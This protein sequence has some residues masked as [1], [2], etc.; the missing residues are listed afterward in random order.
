M[1]Y[2]VGESYPFVAIL[3][4]R[5]DHK[6]TQGMGGTFLPWEHKLI[7]IHVE[8]LKCIEHH[9]VPNY[10]DES[11]QPKLDCDGFIFQ[12]TG[13]AERWNNQYPRAEYGQMSDRADRIVTL[14]ADSKEFVE[15]YWD[16]KVF[17]MEDALSRLSEIHRGVYQLREQAEE[18]KSDPTKFN[19]ST[20]IIFSQATQLEEFAGT[21]QA[22][23]EEV[24]TKKIVVV[25]LTYRMKDS[26]EVHTLKGAFRARFENQSQNHEV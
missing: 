1:R 8:V 9:K 25:P 15:K 18:A 12:N 20:E 24:C 13:F 23:L 4:Q 22:K 26:P 14:A 19:V 3:F 6:E 2:T 21:L 17:Q 7:E 10:W 11:E 5:G 16:T